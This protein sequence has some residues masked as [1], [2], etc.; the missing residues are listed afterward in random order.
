MSIKAFPH[1]KILLLAITCCCMV[2][3]A[4]S[5][6]YTSTVAMAD[7]A[8]R[9]ND[10]FR[11]IDGYIDTEILRLKALKRQA[12]QIP[13]LTP[14][15]AA[16]H[17]LN[18][19]GAYHTI[20]KFSFVWK[21]LAEA[22]ISQTWAAHPNISLSKISK[23]L[24]LKQWPG[25]RDLEGAASALVRLQRTYGLSAVDLQKG[26]VLSSVTEVH[27]DS[28]DCFLIGLEAEKT[29]DWLIMSEWMT[30]AHEKMN[31]QSLFR[32]AQVFISLA[33]AY[34]KLEQTSKAVEFATRAVALDP[35]NKE[36]RVTLEQYKS[37]KEA[38]DYEPEITPAAELSVYEMLC[39]GD[40]L[41]EK[42][43][44]KALNCRYKETN[45]PIKV[46]KEEIL[47]RDP[48]VSIFYDVISNSE[49]QLL[50]DMASSK[51]HQAYI[52]QSKMSAMRISQV[53]WLGDEAADVKQISQRIAQI[54]GLET[55]MKSDM[56][57]AEKFQVVSYGVGGMY[58]PHYDAF[59]VHYDASE[60]PEYL[61]DSGDRVGTWMFYLTDVEAGGATVFPAIK[62][63]VPPVK[64]AA[65]F[66]YNLK[67]DGR[68]DTYTIHAG[69]P[70]LLGQKLV[71][72][73][74]IRERGQIFHRRCG[75]DRNSP[76]D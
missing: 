10:I 26:K 32:E 29:A 55:T 50:V 15:Q 12:S 5:Q 2:C 45:I 59:G 20:K 46:A 8:G 62:V 11:W 13:R 44:E 6:V 4:R 28:N 39:R 27:L 41:Q 43:V 38:C 42:A 22:L 61:R 53:G 1:S 66:W 33:K 14:T 35:G 60:G 40:I 74:W 16:A 31:K 7:L 48:R 71:A 21:K 25:N 34:L 9:E 30:L 65:V 64:N 73:K 70:V 56:S 69:C 52:G 19:L 18:P 75:L 54:T 72:N 36:Y 67:R 24:N 37:T 58:K 49:A 68:R 17:V 51:M 47:Y 63:T 76:D 57:N 3:C 23:D